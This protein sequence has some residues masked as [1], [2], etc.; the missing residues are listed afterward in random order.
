MCE[1]NPKRA[2]TGKRRNRSESGVGADASGEEDARD[3]S[4]RVR[5]GHRAEV[6][7]RCLSQSSIDLIGGI[8]LLDGC[9]A[10]SVDVQT[11]RNFSVSIEAPTDVK[12]QVRKPGHWIEDLRRIGT[13]AE[14]D[15]G[16]DVDMED[17]R[18]H[19]AS[20]IFVGIITLGRTGLTELVFRSIVRV[21][22]RKYDVMV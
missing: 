13:L 14:L 6:S 2:C 10:R 3:A 12:A 5:R 7:G 4:R 15:G 8:D 20:W 11:E 18:P 9:V 22:A 19:R 16:V 1:A 17:R 21:T